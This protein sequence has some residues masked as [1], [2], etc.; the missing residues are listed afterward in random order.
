M[1]F[2]AGEKTTIGHQFPNNVFRQSQQR[3]IHPMP[4]KKKKYKKS[5]KMTKKKKKKNTP[6]KN[7]ST[8]M[9]FKS[10][11]DFSFSHLFRGE[12]FLSPFNLLLLTAIVSNNS[13]QISKTPNSNISPNTGD[14]LF[15]VKLIRSISKRHFVRLLIYCVLPVAIASWVKG[16][17]H[18]TFLAFRGFV[19]F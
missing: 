1:L 6:T 4:K 10:I 7:N 18:R 15:F 9:T 17:V 5:S 8:N 3:I 12:R 2:L 16:R 11:F 14:T 19:S 13:Q